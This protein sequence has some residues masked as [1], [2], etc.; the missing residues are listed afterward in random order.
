LFLNPGRAEAEQ[1]SITMFADLAARC[2]PN[3]AVST[4]AAL[5]TA[6]SNFNPLMLHDNA[7]NLAIS[8]SSVADAARIATHLISRGHSIDVGLMQ[9]NSRNFDML[10][11]TVQTALD[12]CGSISAAAAIL[13]DDYKGGLTHADEQTALRVA[14]S[15]YNSGDS[16][17]GFANGYVRRVELS[18]MRIVPALDLIPSV[19]SGRAPPPGDLPNAGATSPWEI[20]P[21]DPQPAAAGVLARAVARRDALPSTDAGTR[22]GEA[23]VTYP[24]PSD[25]KPREA[26]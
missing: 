3:V 16:E 5:A 1:L 20:F 24:V 12:P 26:P 10:E 11:L 18:A 19:I 21:A 13:T 4:L 17:R 9:V 2:A 7:T 15:R 22:Q 8:P 14:F 25:L 6:E 23:V